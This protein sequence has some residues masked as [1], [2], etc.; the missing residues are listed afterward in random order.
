MHVPAAAYD[1]RGNSLDAEVEGGGGTIYQS[2]ASRHTGRGRKALRIVR[3][4]RTE[5]D[6]KVS[7][8]SGLRSGRGLTINS[9]GLLAS[10]RCG[11]GRSV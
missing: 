1:E 8:S 7:L 3:G 4:E 5:E 10:L 11:V 6:D 2:G 9:L